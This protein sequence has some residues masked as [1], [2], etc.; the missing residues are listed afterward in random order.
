M[1]KSE[2]PKVVAAAY[3]T[4]RTAMYWQN[5]GGSQG[6][7]RHVSLELDSKHNVQLWRF[8]QKRLYIPESLRLEVLRK[9]HDSPWGGHGGQALT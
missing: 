3:E 8:K 2:W 6:K 4:D 5:N 9:Y 7:V 1:I